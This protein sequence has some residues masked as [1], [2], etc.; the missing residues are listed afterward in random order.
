MRA[1]RVARIGMIAALYAATTLV[2]ILFL[3]GLA[4]GPV[5][6]RISEALCVLALFTSDA[7]PGLALGCALANAANIVLG[8]TGMLGLLDVVFGSIATAVGAAITWRL[9]SRPA[10]A[11]LGP[12][13]ANA[14]IVPAYLPLMVAGM[15]FYTIPF[16]SIS[17]EGSYPLMYLFGL[18]T[19]GLGE[20]VVL[21][22]LGLPLAH[23]LKASPLPEQLAERDEDAEG[24]A[25]PARSSRDVGGGRR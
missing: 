24:T 9:R 3:G 25:A 14:L 22:A 12:V 10:V 7:I 2:A 20:A 11:V 21:Y 4:W 17:L 8:G 13:V 18:V 19:T 5:Q 6:F 1:D 23:A 15:G 16:T